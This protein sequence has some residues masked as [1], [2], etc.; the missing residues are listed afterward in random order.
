MHLSLPLSLLLESLG[1]VLLVNDLLAL[2]ELPLNFSKSCNIRVVEP[3]V[4]L[5]ISHGSS[6][7]GI[8]KEEAGDEVLEVITEEGH[9]TRLVLG[10]SFPEEVGT[11]GANKSVE[12]IIWLGPSER[13][14][15]CNHNE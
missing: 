14:V 6:L 2:N 13:W 4:G 7:A 11:V 1:F 12:G 9:A 3:R 15:L 8:E 5:D 10:V